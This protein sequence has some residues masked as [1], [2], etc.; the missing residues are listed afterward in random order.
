MRKRCTPPPGAMREYVTVSRGLSADN[1][2]RSSFV[3][4]RSTCG[5]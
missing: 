3:L 1:R 5:A 4:A 2:E